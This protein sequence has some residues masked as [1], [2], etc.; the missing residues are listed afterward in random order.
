MSVIF[1]CF[2]AQTHPA[3]A[4][5]SQGGPQAQAEY[6]RTPLD[7]VSRDEYLFS[8]LWSYYNELLRR[9]GIHLFRRPITADPWDRIPSDNFLRHDRLVVEIVS[10]I[11][12]LAFGAVFMLAWN[13]PFPTPAEKMIWRAASVFNLI[14]AVVGGAYTWLWHQL[15]LKP[16]QTSE[17]P[18]PPCEHVEKK[19]N[20]AERLRNIS[21]KKDPHLRLPLSALLPI[22][23]LCTIY[24]I[25]RW[26]ILIE[27]LIGLRSLPKSAYDSV[28]WSQFV[29]H[30]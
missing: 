28:E 27:D 1:I 22:S 26:Y 5:V 6:H 20:L 16:R 8:I 15:L 3:V 29:P 23:L 17:E 21:P 4:H 12:I 11:P 13:F 19:K 14:Y 10:G 30:I 9:I 25:C 7:F 2:P 18:E 24:I